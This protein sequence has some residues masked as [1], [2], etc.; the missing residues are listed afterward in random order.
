MLFGE[1][2]TFIYNSICVFVISLTITIILKTGTLGNGYV[3]LVVFPH[4]CAPP[5]I[6]CFQTAPSIHQCY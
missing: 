1:W 4:I 6:L 5:L 3:D 2:Q